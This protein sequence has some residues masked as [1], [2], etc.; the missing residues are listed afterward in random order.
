MTPLI[1]FKVKKLELNDHEKSLQG[2]KEGTLGT[3]KKQRTKYFME[4]F[5]FKLHFSASLPKFISRTPGL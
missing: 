5:S 3:T 4:R 1:F 2:V